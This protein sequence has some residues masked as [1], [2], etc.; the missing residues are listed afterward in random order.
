MKSEIVLTPYPAVRIWWIRHNV[1]YWQTRTD[2]HD[3]G[4]GMATIDW[5]KT[6]PVWARP[7]RTVI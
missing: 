2:D 7:G 1:V 3:Y 4:D 6:S 5:F